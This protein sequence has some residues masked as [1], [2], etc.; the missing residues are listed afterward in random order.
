MISAIA[1]DLDGTL[2]HTLPD[3]YQ[4]AHATLQQFDCPPQ[5]PERVAE[6]LGDGIVTLVHR[7]LTNQRTQ[8]ADPALHQSALS[9]FTDYYAQHVCEES[10]LYPEVRE[11]VHAIQQRGLPQ[12][13]ITNKHHEFAVEILRKL[14][15]L[16][17]FAAVYGGNSLPE[18]K[19]H[20][21][22][23]QTAAKALSLAPAHLLMV[24]DSSN[25][26]LAAQAA[27]CPVVSVAFGYGHWTEAPAGVRAHLQ[28]FGELLSLL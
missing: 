5:S 15:L 1:Y 17:Y 13:V 22:P 4:A 14:E 10:A 19:P 25:D 3:L 18:K 28:H 11:T 12:V 21:L 16:P 8:K 27:G 20:P 7:L 2:C 6:H 23:L 24:G 9:F 26:V